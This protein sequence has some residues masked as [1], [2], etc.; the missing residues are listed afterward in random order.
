MTKKVRVHSLKE[1]KEIYGDLLKLAKS[2]LHHGGEKTR[3]A[4]I[5]EMFDLL[6]ATVEIDS[7]GI[8]ISDVCRGLQLESWMYEKPVEID[9]EEISHQYIGKLAQRNSKHH[10]EIGMIT[11]IVVEDPEKILARMGDKY[12]SLDELDFLGA[13]IPLISEEVL[14]P[15]EMWKPKTVKL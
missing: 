2:G 11:S 15:N 9:I 14:D 1:M 10:K 8:I 4:M 5:P 13:S 7:H 3:L 6:G 12:Y